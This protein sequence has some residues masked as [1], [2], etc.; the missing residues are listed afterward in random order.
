M[1]IISVNQQPG[2]RKPLH[3][4]IAVG[5]KETNASFWFIVLPCYGVGITSLMLFQIKRAFIT[6]IEYKYKYR[7]QDEKLWVLG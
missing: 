2:Q 4:Y 3:L 5:R 6:N 7:Y 1:Q